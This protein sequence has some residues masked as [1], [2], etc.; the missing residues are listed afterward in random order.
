MKKKISLP[1][2]LFY[3]HYYHL[4]LPSLLFTVAGA[5]MLRTAV[6]IILI[7]SG[8]RLLTPLRANTSNYSH[9]RVLP[10]TATTS[11]QASSNGRHH[12]RRRHRRRLLDIAD[13]HDRTLIESNQCK[14]SNIFLWSPEIRR[15]HSRIAKYSLTLSFSFLMLEFRI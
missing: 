7:V 9:T 8:H 3:Y 5:H 15:I 1:L 11:L 6:I 4:P 13:Q 12:R 14:F 2:P 10:V